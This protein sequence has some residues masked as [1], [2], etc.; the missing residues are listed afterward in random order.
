MKITTPARYRS[1]I[2]HCTLCGHKVE[3]KVPPGDNRERHVCPDCGEIQYQNP[4]IVTG[5]IP[6]WEDRLLVCKR[7]IEP[8]RGFWT[9]PAGF[10]ENDESVAEGAA[11]ETWE[12]ACA[13]VANLELYQIFNVRR[14]NQIYMLFRAELTAPDRFGV[15]EESLETLLVPEDEVPWADMA[16][17][18]IVQT[19]ERFF[20][21]RALGQFTVEINDL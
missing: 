17:P 18:V 9:I 13:E 19:L 16:F 6:T 8:R 10:M 12:E 7:A 3:V 4:K 1:P 2:L 15:G 20:A 5:C 11:R 14:V 21:E